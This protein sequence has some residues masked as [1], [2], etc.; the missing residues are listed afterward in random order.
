M[1]VFTIYL[2]ISNTSFNAHL[3]FVYYILT[4]FITFSLLLLL[5]FPFLPFAIIYYL[6]Y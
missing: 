6:I 4:R 3:I 2:L 5:H 1:T